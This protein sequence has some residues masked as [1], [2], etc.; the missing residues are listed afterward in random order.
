VPSTAGLGSL[1]PQGPNAEIIADLWW[2]MLAL[3]AVAFGV[4][5]VALGIGL[6]RRPAERPG[7][8]TQRRL[9]RWIVGGGV[10]LPTVVV[11]VVFGATVQAMRALPADPSDDALVVEVTGFQWRYEVSYPAEGV[12]VVDELHL[13]VG[14]E[15]ALHLKSED[16]IHSFWV[17]ELGGKLDMLPDG[18]NVLVLQA[19]QPGEWGARCAEFCGL[20]HASMVLRVVAEAPEQFDAWLATQS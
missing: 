7:E 12:R 6:T 1:D 8:D 3:G 17:P 15:V 16:V 20:H 19:D 11:L 10:V 14:R 2:L 13:P 5:A 18:T 4:F 9:D